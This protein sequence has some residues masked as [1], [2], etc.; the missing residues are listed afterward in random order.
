MRFDI[1][2]AADVRAV[3]ASFAAAVGRRL[4]TIMPEGV[5]RGFITG[6]AS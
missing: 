5:R 3:P 6:A 4:V 1:G 2:G